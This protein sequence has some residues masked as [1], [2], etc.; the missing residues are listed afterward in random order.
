M[1]VNK[2]G[3]LAIAINFPL[4]VLIGETNKIYKRI[5]IY[6][7]IG[8]KA[9]QQLDSIFLHEGLCSSLETKLLQSFL[10]AS[11]CQKSS[12]YLKEAA[13]SHRQCPDLNQLESIRTKSFDLV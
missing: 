4:G 5:H 7:D 3:V 9:K 6:L 11:A 10:S 8:W 2:V 1:L 13:F 12:P